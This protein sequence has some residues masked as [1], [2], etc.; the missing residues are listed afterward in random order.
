M[1]I[2]IDTAKKIIFIDYSNM[3][4]EQ[5]IAEAEKVHTEGIRARSS[6]MKVKVF[7]DVRGAYLNPESVK[8][9]KDITK[10]DNDIVEKTAI[11]G[12]T[13]LKRILADAIAAFSGTKTKYFDTKEQAIEWLSQP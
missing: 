3:K 8:A 1:P 13:G 6:G 12:I 5:L 7:V 2:T 10:K 4:P 9:L 11:V